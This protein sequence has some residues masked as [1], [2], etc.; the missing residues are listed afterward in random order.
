M[1]LQAAIGVAAQSLVNIGDGFGVISQNIANANTRGYG[2]EQT[3]QRSL[4]AGGEGFGAAIGPTQLVS[5]SILSRQLFGENAAAGAATTTDGALSNLQPVLGTV[6]Q[7]ND[8][9]SLLGGLQSSF[10]ALLTDPSNQAQQ[11]AVVG[12]AQSVT[13]QINAL[14]AAYTQARQSAQDGLAANVSD[15]DTALGQVGALS[16][17]IVALQAQGQSTADLQNQRNQALTTISGLVGASFISQP[18]GDVLIHT[19]GGAEL[20]TRGQG[21]G[22]LAAGQPLSVATAVVT[23][24]T[25]YANGTLPGIVLD[26]ADVTGELSGGAIGANVALRDQTLPAYQGELD[27]FSQTLATRFAGQGLSLFT[28]PS[29]TI[30]AAGATPVQ[31]NYVGF[32]GSITVNPAVVAQPS[33]VRDGNITVAGSPTGPAAF[34][35]NPSGL[36]GFAGLINNVL[37]FALG[38]QAQAGV[39][40]TAPAVAGLGAAGN[41]A[42]PFAPPASLADFATDIT[43]S[44]AAD[45]ASASS[46]AS[47]AT[48]T[49]TAL[50]GQLQSAT[51]VDVDSQ[52]S[53][54]V[55]LQNAYG[56]NAKIMDAVQDM[57]TQLLQ[58]VQ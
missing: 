25:A 35:P 37:N 48:G 55:T 46:S 45:A 58:A 30:P 14:S 4:D 34:T 6:G 31:A 40:Q 11:S 57:Y 36:A 18:N 8:L 29:G 16:N 19:N 7:G 32:A 33:L 44:Q 20:P 10:S 27:E 17:Q 22:L 51:G 49:Q 54:L 12:A 39:A 38:T 53:L 42:A 5:D 13:Q 41:L 56:A 21:G 15:L 43:A 2:V 26:G 50:S 52:L 28:T 23:P 47:D 1:S 9:G 24:Q 3:T